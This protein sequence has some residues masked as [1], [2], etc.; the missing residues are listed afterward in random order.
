M[1]TNKEPWIVTERREGYG[2]YLARGQN[3]K[4]SAEKVYQLYSES[5]GSARFALYE[6]FLREA[7]LSIELIS[8]AALSQH[9][10]QGTTKS[11]LKKMPRT[12]NLFKIFHDLDVV[13]TTNRQAYFLDFLTETLI[14]SGRYGAPNEG[15][16]TPISRGKRY[17]SM[18]SE[19]TKTGQKI[20][21]LEVLRH[22]FLEWSDFEE[23]YQLAFEKFNFKN[24]Y[25]IPSK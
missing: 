17:D 25:P 8:K 20:G 1:E 13:L 14:W 18:I 4:Y 7:A 9:I 16:T 19:A 10:R 21:S 22:P 5:S 2:W 6:A 3:A 23:L 11:G 12:H 15:K 24:N